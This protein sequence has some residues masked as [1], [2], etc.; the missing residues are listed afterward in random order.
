MLNLS[1]TLSCFGLCVDFK[2]QR[3]ESLTSKFYLTAKLYLKKLRMNYIRV[4]EASF[5]LILF[6]RPLAKVRCISD[7]IVTILLTILARTVHNKIN[8]SQNTEKVFLLPE[9]GACQIKNNWLLS[10]EYQ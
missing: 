4:L 10:L 6:S 8:N 3:V 1:L 9:F 5:Y 7:F 2:G